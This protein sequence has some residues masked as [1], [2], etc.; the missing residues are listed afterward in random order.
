[1]NAPIKVAVGLS[2]GV[3]SS[4]TAAL[5]VEAG[6]EVSGLTMRI[7]PGGEG[8]REGCKHGC[9]GPGEEEDIAA[10]QAL[11]E[12]LRIPYRVVD[13]VREYEHTVMEYFRAEYLKGRTPNPCV[14]CNHAMKFGFLLDRARLE[15]LDFDLFATGHYARIGLRNGRPCLRMAADGS[16]DQ[17]Y[18]LHRLGPDTLTHVLFPLGEKTKAEVRDIARRMGLAVAEKPESQDFISGGDYSSVFAEVESRP[19]DIVDPEGRVLGTHTGIH[20]YTIGQRRGIGVSTGPEP[21]YVWALDASK[22]RVVVGPNQGLFADGLEAENVVLSDPALEGAPFSAR[23]RIRQNHRPVPAEVLVENGRAK[24]RFDVAQRAV[25]PG[26]SSV[27]Y[28]DEGFVLGGGIIERAVHGEE[29]PLL[30]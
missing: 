11:C 28:D 8:A 19:G 13:L 27:F 4:V 22:N 20:Q 24:V 26:Q 17:S 30:G 9:Y 14:L 3:D 23:V 7:W 2:G 12:R 16:K 18:F 21:L 6:Y 1:M 29:A 10:C 15:G 5:L 25:A